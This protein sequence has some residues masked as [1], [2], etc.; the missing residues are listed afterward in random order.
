MQ[1]ILT[2]NFS[3]LYKKRWQR[4]FCSKTQIKSE[5]RFW[6][7]LLFGFTRKSKSSH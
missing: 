5:N 2:T 4:N 1:H 7:L 6:S 3:Y